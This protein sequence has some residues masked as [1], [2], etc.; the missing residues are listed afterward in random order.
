MSYGH[1]P[2]LLRRAGWLTLTVEVVRA[3]C[4][5]L[6]VLL[7]AG[8][9]ALGIDAVLGLYPAALIAVDVVLLGIFLLAAGYIGRQAWRNRFNPRRVARQI[10]LRLGLLDSRLINSVDLVDAPSRSYS[11]Q[12][13]QQ[14]VQKGEELAAQVSSLEVVDLRRPWK[15]AA[16]AVGAIFVLLIAYLAA[17]RV[18]ATVVPRYLDPTGD[19]PPF[20]LLTFEIAVTPE[21]VY[22]GKPASISA[23]L[24]GPDRPEQANLVFVDG[25]ERQPLP[26]FRNEE[27]TFVLPIERADASREFYIETPKG[28]S[29]RYM[30]SVL[31]VPSFER[32]EVAY[33][34]PKY[35]GWPS[36]GH[37]LDSRGIR[38]LEKTEILVSA[39][40]SMPLR[41][42]RLE[43]FNADDKSAPASGAAI[44]T[45]TL[46]PD[47]K[48]VSTVA[49]RF[50]LESS[51]RYRLTLVGAN[52]AE[53]HEQREG[54]LVCVPDQLP[55][56]A[57]V[58][59]EPL[60]AAV[61]GWKVPVTVQAIDDVGIDRILLFA[62]V[63]GWGPD[64]TPLNLQATQ[65]TVVQ[66]H[67]TFDLAALGARA[68][69]IIT[70][71]ASAYDNHPSG[72]HFADTPT[73]VI[74]VI[75]QAEFAE[76]ARQKYQM[77][78]LAKEFDAFRRRLE[79]LKSRRDKALEELVQLQKK[80]DAGKPLGAEELRKMTQLEAQLKEYAE[81]AQKLAKDLHERAAQT[82]LYDLE[83]SYRDGLERLAKQLD[84]QADHAEQLRQQAAQLR[85]QPANP[86]TAGAFR[87]AAQK[88][89]KEQAPFDEPSQQQLEKTAQDVEKLRLA[90]DLISQGE[91]LR[92]AVLQQ[93]ELADRMAQFRDRNKLTEEDLHRSQRL[94]KDQELLRQEV[95][96]ARA[97]LQKTAQ[98]AQ[99][100]LPKMSGGA[101]KVCKAIDE[102]QIG[103]DQ[104]QAAR[105][106]RGGEGQTAY[107]AADSAAKKLESL[108]SNSCTPK[109]AAESGDLDGCFSLS[110][111]GLQQSLG[112]M[113]QGRQLPGLG[114]QQ[115]G[116]G[117]GFAGSQA[118]MAI[119][120][121]HQLSQGDS[122]NVRSS[123]SANHGQGDRGFGQ[124]RD[125]ARRAEALN[126]AARQTP[127]SAAGNL[128][129][130]PLGYRE[131]AE[132]YFK[133]I[134]KEQ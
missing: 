15:A 72:S 17:P 45:I 77:D 57:I 100:S 93:R 86:Q 59:P 41:A 66:G 63:N 112:Q 70:Y 37:E 107:E 28:R 69:D 118:R 40:A 88:L 35:T 32:A 133:R 56:V 42:G 84:K 131:Q 71:Y 130:V 94:A 54:P 60:V 122:D 102:L 2:L 134:A 82:Q 117:S 20:T 95:E 91:R 23:T 116:Q 99:K 13:V 103:N 101:L 19:H 1:L 27:G 80:L 78:Q 50:T 127:R 52:G 111:P 11:P 85:K 67:Y 97:E 36:T 4:G 21:T 26:M 62:G 109:G 73:S 65:P 22:Q 46:E 29:I 120:G 7:A 8:L 83:K 98:A 115:G 121:P 3:V 76:Y 6:G 61:E 34:F 79:N 25:K 39:T 96:E 74:H 24:S 9:A 30:F 38:A 16:A 125:G 81:Q 119:F 55:Q 89:Q 110:K 47:G 33:Q 31:A 44:K 51:G 90:N 129:G 48:E 114:Q 124:D 123:G 43:I 108:L 113:S 68:G 14:S 87:D 132:A 18:F 58:E 104:A 5:T 106:A 105:S 49:G 10:E 126:P 53:S 128:H 75:S 64:P 12:L 92:A